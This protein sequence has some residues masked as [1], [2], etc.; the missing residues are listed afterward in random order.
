MTATSEWSGRKTRLE[1]RPASLAAKQNSHQPR[2]ALGAHGARRGVNGRSRIEN[3][4]EAVRPGPDPQARVS[5]FSG[6]ST[7]FGKV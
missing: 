4:I 1:E 6:G 5:F 2:L 7:L 3:A